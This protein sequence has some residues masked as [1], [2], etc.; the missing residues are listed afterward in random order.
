MAHPAGESEFA[1]VRLDFDGFVV[2][3]QFKFG[4][5]EFAIRRRAQNGPKLR[6]EHFCDLEGKPNRAQAERRIAFRFE[7][8]EL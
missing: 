4:T 7:A 8:A 1:V 2:I 5:V 6:A 3:V